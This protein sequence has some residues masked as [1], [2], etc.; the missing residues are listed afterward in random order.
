MI[1]WPVKYNWCAGSSPQL[2][3]PVRPSWRVPWVWCAYRLYGIRLPLRSILLWHRIY[4]PFSHC[5]P[6][7][8]LRAITSQKY[9]QKEKSIFSYSVRYANIIFL[10]HLPLEPTAFFEPKWI[11]EYLFEGILSD[12]RN[13]NEWQS[14]LVSWC[15][16]WTVS[17]GYKCLSANW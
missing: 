15:R 10:F 2:C 9:P 16:R 1:R 17:V 14:F 6:R 8:S 12:R 7:Y 13:A 5:F 11:Q 3:R 4:L